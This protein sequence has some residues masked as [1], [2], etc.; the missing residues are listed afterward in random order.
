[1]DRDC[2]F[3]R[4]DVRTLLIIVTA[5]WSDRCIYSEALYEDDSFPEH[6]LAAIVA[7]KVY[8]HLQ[9]YNESMAFA[10]GAGKHFRLNNPGEFEDTIISKCV[11]TYIALSAS[12]DPTLAAANA[13]THPQL[14]EAFGQG[15]DGAASM[16][17]S[18]T[19][20]VTPFSQSVLPSKS[21]LSRQNTITFDPTQAGVELGEVGSPERMIQ[22]RGLGKA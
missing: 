14:D 12:R 7:S 5:C 22:E 13:S 8:Y 11:D 3:R 16:S 10:L 2:Q 20:P 19:S 9:E 17:A 6:D 4:R 21:L 18:L 15:G 1:M